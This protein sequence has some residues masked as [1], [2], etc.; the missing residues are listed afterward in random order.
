VNDQIGRLTFTTD[1][2]KGIKHL[3]DSKAPYGTYNLTNTGDSVSW[4][5]VAGIV[6]ELAGHDK[7][8]V[9]GISTQEYYKDKEGIAPRPLQSTLSLDKIESTGFTPR[10]WREALTD[11]LKN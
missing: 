4:A 10:D 11:Y 5:D 9:T 1:L 2:A 6:Y 8:D 7:S 3:V